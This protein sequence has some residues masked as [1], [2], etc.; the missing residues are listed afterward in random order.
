MRQRT[1]RMVKIATLAC[2]IEMHQCH[3]EWLFGYRDD[4]VSFYCYFELLLRGR[5]T[6]AMLV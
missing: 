3:K 1:E 6:L 2:G 5:T 4:T